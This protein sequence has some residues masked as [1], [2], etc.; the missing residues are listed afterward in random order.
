MI[1]HHELKEGFARAQNFFGIGDDLHAG[2]D[3]AD[4]G[5]GEYARAG[6]HN[7]EAADADGSLILNVA[8]RGDVDA[9]HARGIEDAGAGGHADGLAVESDVDHPGRCGGGGHITGGSRRAGLHR[10]APQM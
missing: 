9:V 8:K 10:R 3:R 5:S 4:A 6:V 7:A 2:L 1:G